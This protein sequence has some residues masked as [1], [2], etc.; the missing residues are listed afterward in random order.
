MALAM[1]FIPACDL[2]VL[3]IVAV[4]ATVLLSLALSLLP[5]NHSTIAY[6]VLLALCA[7]HLFIE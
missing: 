4:P 2:S 6:W 1:L 5:V 7:L 3:A